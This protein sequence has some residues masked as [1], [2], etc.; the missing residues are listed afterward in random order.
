MVAAL[1]LAG[2]ALFIAAGLAV[3]ARRVH[4]GNLDAQAL[5]EKLAVPH[6]VSAL[7]WPELRVRAVVPQPGQPLLVVLLVGWPGF[8]DRAAT[9]LAGLDDEGQPVALLARWCADG[10]SVAPRRR[11]GQEFE[12]RRRQSLERVSGSLL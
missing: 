8:D 10:A 2:A 3:A 9:L 4:I 5:A 12:L 11:G 6:P 7:G 1:A